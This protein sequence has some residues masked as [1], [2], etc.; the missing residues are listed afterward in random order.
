MWCGEGGR[1]RASL[2]DSAIQGSFA[3]LQKIEMYHYDAELD[4]IPVWDSYRWIL[5]SYLGRVNHAI[6]EWLSLQRDCSVITTCWV[7][8]VKCSRLVS[9][10]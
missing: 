5:A 3:F 7:G 2:P 8:G 1:Q 10:D 4:I 9:L 6:P